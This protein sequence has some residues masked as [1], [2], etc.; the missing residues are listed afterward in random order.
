LNTFAIQWLFLIADQTPRGEEHLSSELE[1]CGRI[2]PR[3]FIPHCS[4]VP[5]GASC[6]YYL[7]YDFV[8]AK[9]VHRICSACTVGGLANE[10]V[11]CALPADEYRKGG[12]EAS[13]SVSGETIGQA[14]V[15]SASR[16]AAAW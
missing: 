9:N 8:I 15:Y 6:Q 11:S 3:T 14:L 7:G 13:M 5:D 2:Q 10:W 16:A 4:S 12:Y 1:T